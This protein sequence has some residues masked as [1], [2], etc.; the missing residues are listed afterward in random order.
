VA[1]QPRS[2]GLLY[3]A[4]AGDNELR[5]WDC[6][7]ARFASPAAVDAAAASGLPASLTAF[8]RAGVAVFRGHAGAVFDVAV[9]GAAPA[10]VATAGADGRGLLWDCRAGTL[11]ISN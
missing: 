8:E 10:V 9:C 7:R 1:F 3:T 11:S 5:L 4:G 6:S 2:A